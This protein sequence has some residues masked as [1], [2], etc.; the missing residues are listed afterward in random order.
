MNFG[1]VGTKGQT[2]IKYLDSPERVVRE[3]QKLITEKLRK[4][5]QEQAGSI[6]TG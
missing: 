5:Y 2:L 6:T 4:G 3:A 1:R